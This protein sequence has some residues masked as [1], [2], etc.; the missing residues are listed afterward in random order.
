MSQLSFAHVPQAG[1]TAFGST[2]STGAWAL[3]DTTNYENSST[4]LWNAPMTAVVKIRMKRTVMGLLEA[5]AGAGGAKGCDRQWDSCQKQLNGLLG[6]AAE[7]NNTA[8]REAA[9]RLQKMLLLGAG[10][11]QT[12]LRYQEEVDFARKQAALTSQG[13]GA[14]DV[15]LLGLGPIMAE[16]A[17]ATDALA[18]AIGHGETNRTPY[19]RKATAAMECA[20]TFAWAADTLSWMVEHGGEGAER[21]LAMALHASLVELAERYVATAPAALAQQA[22]PP[23]A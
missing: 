2:M 8:K 22:A 9:E 3:V 18:A 23:N 4:P 5:I 12:Q 6:V 11:G 20:T 17:S 13:Q 14:A 15:A 1:F 21:E 19:R 10:A 16:I 7:S